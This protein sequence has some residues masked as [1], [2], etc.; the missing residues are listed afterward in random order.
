MSKKNGGQ[1]VESIDHVVE[2][3]I[4]FGFPHF[5]PSCKPKSDIFHPDFD[6]AAICLGDFWEQTRA[7]PDLIVHIGK[8]IN[9]EIYSTTNA[10]NEEAAEWYLDNAVKFPLAHISW[11]NGSR[12]SSAPHRRHE[13]DTLDDSDLAPEFDFLALEEG[14]DDE[15]ITLNT[16]FPE[17]GITPKID[18]QPFTQL[19]RQKKYYT[20][21]NTAADIKTPSHELT[22]LCER[23]REEI[24]RV[25]K[26]HRDGKKFENKGEAQIALEKY[27]QITSTVADF[28]T[29][30]SDIHRVKQTLALLDDISPGKTLD[31]SAPQPA[32]KSSPPVK[33]GNGAASGKKGA[34][35]AANKGATVKPPTPHDLFL[36]KD[37]KKSRLPLFLLL[38]L[39]TLV[40]AAGGYLWYSFTNKLSSAEIAYAACSTA[41]ANNQFKEAKNSCDKALRLVGEVRFIHQD[42]ARQLE[43]FI[44]EILTSEKLTKGLAGYI[45]LDGKYVPINETK[46]LLSIKQQLSEAESLFKASKWQPALQQYDTLLAQIEGK[47]YVEPSIIEGL[48]RK[49]QIAK[50]RMFYD[51]AQMA[52]QKKEWETAIEKLLQAQ[53]VLVDLPESDREQYSVE[54]QNELQKSQFANLKEQGDLS[55]TGTDWLSAIESYNL[56]LASGRKTALP[57]ESIDAIK[58]NIKR[59]ELYNSINKGNKSFAAASWDEAIKAYSTA[60]SLLIGTKAMA[61]EVD[62]DVNIQKLDRII[63]QAKIIR[64]RQ[65]LETQLKDNALAKARRTYQQILTNIAKSSLKGEEEFSNTSAETSKAMQALDK[66]IFLQSKEAYLQN[67]YQTLFVANYPNATAENLSNP[68]IT[69]TKETAFKLV[70]KMQCTEN[71]GGRPLNMVMFYSYDKNTG[72][73]SF[74]SEK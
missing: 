12:S 11:G 29:I 8:M 59:A 60:R 66:K 47:G 13:V 20:L 10:F 44:Q 34:S 31:F 68:V 72:R 61:K 46:A 7:L 3:A 56:A 25:E 71:D 35:K 63:L 70:F 74:Y 23:A 5:P 2:L 42:F 26:L 19:Q 57:P 6:P 36:P 17:V 16:S 62:T 32:D 53:K 50:F 24:E 14:K 52:I 33:N 67:N 1:I 73:W 40:I 65:I 28:P 30:D 49:R 39:M 69:F 15:D 18:L 54:L 22:T 9:G 43:K 27:Q 58:N 4:P 51:P 37:H 45:L 21:L 41:I 48:H 55:F 38:G 64:D